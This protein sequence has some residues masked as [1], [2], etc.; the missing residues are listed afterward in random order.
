MMESRPVLT[1]LSTAAEAIPG[2]EENTI[3]HAGP[4]IEWD[5]MSGPLRGAVIGALLLEGL[6]EDE[7]QAIGMAEAGEVD[8]DPCH[9][10]STVGPMAGVV[11]PSMAV[12]VVEDS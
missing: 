6:A 10:H 11:S 5:R 7:D 4:P 8:F 12:Y 3:L 9:E 2:M 1:G